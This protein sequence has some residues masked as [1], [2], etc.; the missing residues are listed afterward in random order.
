MTTERMN[1]GIKE[2]ESLLKSEVGEH[3]KIKEFRSGLSPGELTLFDGIFLLGYR[4]GLLLNL[5]SKSITPK[6]KVVSKFFTCNDCYFWD[7]PSFPGNCRISTREPDTNGR[8]V[9]KRTENAD[10]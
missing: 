5:G 8:C 10:K 9:F 2:V 1:Y 6:N 7:T 4:E 3:S